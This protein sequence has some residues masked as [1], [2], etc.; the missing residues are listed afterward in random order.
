MKW[1][2]QSMQ[3]HKCVPIATNKT[4]IVNLAVLCTALQVLS[5]NQTLNSLLDHTRVWFKEGKLRKYLHLQLL[6]PQ[7]LSCLH[8]SHNRRLNCVI[9]VLLDLLRIVRCFSG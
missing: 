7:G 5:F 9:S 4:Y 3:M 8:G 1:L 2:D 6:M